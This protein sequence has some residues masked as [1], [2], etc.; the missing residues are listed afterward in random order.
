MTENAQADR[1]QGGTT[2]PVAEEAHVGEQANGRRVRNALK[3]DYWR[4]P[5]WLLAFTVLFVCVGGLLTS[6]FSVCKDETVTKGADQTVTRTCNGPS[7]SDAGVVAIALLIVLLFAPDMSEVGVLG[8][9]LKRRLATAEAKAS[10]SA[11]KAERLEDRIQVQ[12]SRIEMLSQNLAMATANAQAI[13]NVYLTT[14]DE[15]RQRDSGLAQKAEAFKRGVEPEPT[16]TAGE[17]V[18]EALDAELAT[19]LIRDW[20]VL[21]ASLD[22]PPYRPGGRPDIPRVVVSSDEANRFVN[23]FADELKIVRAARNNVAHARPIT[24]DDLRA[25]VDISDRLLAILQ[26]S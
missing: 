8:V 4:I 16:T 17:L 26:G 15:I 5:R 10:E 20:E 11:E 6:S 19:R 12:N 1:L 21:A 18:T 13:S 14:S 9:S 22:L 2:K 3:A 24:N 23:V 25:A 7:V